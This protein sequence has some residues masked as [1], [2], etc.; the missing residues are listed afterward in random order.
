MLTWHDAS[1][2]VETTTPVLFEA[3]DVAAI[4][5]YALWD[6]IMLVAAAQAG[7]RVLLSEDLHAGFIWRGVEVKRPF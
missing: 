3:M 7:C 6:S 4:H 5:Q 1:V 2:V